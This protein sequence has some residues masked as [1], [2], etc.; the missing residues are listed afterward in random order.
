MLVNQSFRHIQPSFRL[1]WVR[2]GIFAPPE[3]KSLKDVSVKDV[4]TDRVWLVLGLRARNK[5]DNIDI[6]RRGSYS[7]IMAYLS[8][9]VTVVILSRYTDTNRNRA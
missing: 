2:S 6:R 1:N 3:N 5:M 4:R 9:F 8:N 7:V